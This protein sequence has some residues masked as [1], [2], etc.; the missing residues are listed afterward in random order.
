MREI[1]LPGKLAHFD[2]DEI[3]DAFPDVNSFPIKIL[4]SFSLSPKDIH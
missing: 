1:C 4:K 3:C 2:Y